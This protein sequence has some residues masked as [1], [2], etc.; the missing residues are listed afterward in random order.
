MGAERNDGKE[1]QPQS[2][3]S[4]FLFSILIHFLVSPFSFPSALF[5]HG[6]GPTDRIVG[7]SLDSR[8]CL[9]A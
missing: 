9:I 4:V 3:E 1:K 5:E 7:Y 8:R 2:T 6:L